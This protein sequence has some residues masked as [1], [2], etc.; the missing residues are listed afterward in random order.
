MLVNHQIVYFF[1]FCRLCAYVHIHV[2]SCVCVFMGE[3]ACPCKQACVW[4]QRLTLGIIPQ[5]GR[6]RGKQRGCSWKC[7]KQ[8]SRI[9]RNCS[10]WILRWSFS[11]RLG[12]CQ[13]GFKLAGQQT[14]GI[15][16]DLPPN[17]GIAIKAGLFMWL[18]GFHLSS[19]ACSES[20][21]PTEL[22]LQPQELNYWTSY[23]IY[24]DEHL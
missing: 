7:L 14:P 4:G 1:V 10:L 24:R 13:L 17:T 16:L 6:E 11:L 3:C 20:T 21:L 19:H 15:L 9:L 12:A 8:N 2:F 18:W 23:F 5:D 22:S